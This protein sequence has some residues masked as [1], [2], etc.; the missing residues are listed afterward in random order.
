MANAISVAGLDSSDSGSALTLTKGT[1]T[2]GATQAAIADVV[3]PGDLTIVPTAGTTG[4]VTL[5]ATALDNVIFDSVTVAN[6]GA[7]AATVQ[8]TGAAALT[9]GGAASTITSGVG[10]A[11]TITINA[12]TH[13]TAV[14]ATGVDA[15]DPIVVTKGTVALAPAIAS[16]TVTGTTHAAM[17]ADGQTPVSL[18]GATAAG[19]G[20]GIAAQ[21]GGVAPTRLTAPPTI[22]TGGLITIGAIANVADTK[23]D[24]IVC[25][26][27]A[28][29]TAR[30]ATISVTG[31]NGAASASA[32]NVVTQEPE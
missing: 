5:S 7:A 2:L 9:V 14:T 26:N 31:T 27:A 18:A 16:V 1:V 19:A 22:T 6:T 28:T 15:N 29:T 8:V 24:K 32:I 4:L 3:A 13:A 20:V 30:I 11:N 23:V 21:V 10:N 12:A 17:C 25:Q